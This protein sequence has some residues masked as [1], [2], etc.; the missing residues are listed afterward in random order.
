MK[1][2][3]RALTR[4]L[5]V[6]VSLRKFRNTRVLMLVDN[7]S[8]CFSFERRRARAFKLL[9][10]IRK[11]ASLSLALNLRVSFRWIASE[12]NATDE[13]SRKFDPEYQRRL[14]SEVCGLDSHR[15]IG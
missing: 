14:A 6:S 13:P 12:A 11:L 4:G 7:M 9:L 2:E 8:V 15:H 5:E 3:S 1:L 10:Q